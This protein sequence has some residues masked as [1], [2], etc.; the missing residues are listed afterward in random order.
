M[1]LDW[2]VP[3]AGIPFGGETSHGFVR[4]GNKDPFFIEPSPINIP[5]LL[6]TTNRTFVTHENEE[7]N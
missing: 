6:V 5:T 7:C 3:H 4:R 1:S 2:F